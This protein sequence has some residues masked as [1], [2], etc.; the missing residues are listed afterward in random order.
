MLAFNVEQPPPAVHRAGEGAGSAEILS[1]IGRPVAAETWRTA[2]LL[3]GLGR[4]LKPATTKN[5]S[6]VTAEPVVMNCC[7]LKSPLNWWHRLL[8]GAVGAGFKPAPARGRICRE[9]II[10]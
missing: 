4:R 5:F 3:R 2:D 7:S 9:T 1:I 10:K 6:I 8:A